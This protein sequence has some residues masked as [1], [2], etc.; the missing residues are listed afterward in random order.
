MTVKDQNDAPLM[1]DDDIKAN[2]QYHLADADD[3]DGVV[4]EDALQKVNPQ[5]AERITSDH[6]PHGVVK[7]GLNAKD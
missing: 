2:R 7:N 3:F 6:D 4:P 1:A 5:L